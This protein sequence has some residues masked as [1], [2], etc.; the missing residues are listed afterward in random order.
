ME[1]GARSQE[2]GARRSQPGDRSWEIGG[3]KRGRRR[4]FGQL[5]NILILIFLDENAEHVH[6]RSKRMVTLPLV[7]P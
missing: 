1:P 3:R 6:E 4:L 7:H 2:Q 5:R